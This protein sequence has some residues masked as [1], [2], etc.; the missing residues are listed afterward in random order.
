MQRKNPVRFGQLLYKKVCSAKIK[1]NDTP[2]QRI[3][4]RHIV[5]RR[6][7]GLG[8]DRLRPHHCRCDDSASFKTT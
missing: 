4:V 1:V 3:N 6:I 5:E 7:A 8:N 2:F